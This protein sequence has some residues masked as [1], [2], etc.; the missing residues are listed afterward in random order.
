MKPNQKLHYA[1][2]I[3]LCC[4]LA[5]F[6]VAGLTSTCFSVFSPYLISQAGLS[7][8]QTSSLL[9]IRGLASFLALFVVTQYTSKLGLR[10]GISLGTLAT[11]L[12]FLFYAIA[13]KS[14]LLYCVPQIN[15]P[16]RRVR[17]VFGGRMLREIP[18]KRFEKRH[19]RRRKVAAQG[20]GQ[21]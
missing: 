18:P 12:G 4:S 14:Y 21:R 10:A 2:V 8:A 11:A 16:P 7:G 15:E 9:T 17:E 19:R 20:D 6:C 1:W 3:C 5:M 13:G